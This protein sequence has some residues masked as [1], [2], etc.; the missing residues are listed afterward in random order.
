MLSRMADVKACRYRRATHQR[1][2]FAVV[3]GNEAEILVRAAK[4]FTEDAAQCR[5][6][7]GELSPRTRMPKAVPPVQRLARIGLPQPVG[8]QVNVNDG[9]IAGIAERM[10][11]GIFR[12]DSRERHHRVSMPRQIS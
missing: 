7:Q 4:A 10:P 9:G 8:P 5:A 1:A 3:Q 2:G 11:P 6:T 12:E